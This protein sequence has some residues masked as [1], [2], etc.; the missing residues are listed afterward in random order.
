[1]V[2]MDESVAMLGLGAMEMEPGFKYG[3]DNYEITDLEQ[4]GV[5]MPMIG[6]IPFVGYVFQ[7]AEGTDVVNFMSDLEENCNPHWMECDGG[8]EI[9]VT[10]GAY[11]NYV[12][13][14]MCP[15]SLGE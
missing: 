10:C 6:S 5:F 15:A 14:L 8:A 9:A 13:F 12:F 4:C 3:F 2:T 1:M 11:G 7:L